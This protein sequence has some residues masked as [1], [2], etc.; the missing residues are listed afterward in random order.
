MKLLFWDKKRDVKM[1]RIWNRES[2]PLVVDF[3]TQINQ[4]EAG[5]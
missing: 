5:P 4:L 2:R 1:C 3:G